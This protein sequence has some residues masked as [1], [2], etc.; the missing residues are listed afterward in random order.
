MPKKKDDEIGQAG[1][2]AAPVDTAGMDEEMKS[3]LGLGKSGRE[4]RPQ[5]GAAAPKANVG[6]P[7]NR[8]LTTSKNLS[9]IQDEIQR[10]KE[11]NAGARVMR[12]RE[13]Q[14]RNP[15]RNG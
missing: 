1:N 15:R 14:L 3:T 10:Q 13:G 8:P 7:G 12:R 5:G 9:A 6:T 4:T 11:V 2:Y